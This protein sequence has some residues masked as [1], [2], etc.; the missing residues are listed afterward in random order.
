[1]DIGESLVGAYMRH[2]RNCHTIAFNQFTPG[3]QGEIDVIGI[4]GN[5]SDQK[6][7]IAEVAIHLDGLNYGTYAE[8]VNKIGAKI[9]TAIEYSREIYRNDQPVVEF[10]AP[11]VARGLVERLAIP[12]V[13]FVVNDAF[14][15]RVNELAAIAATSTK[16]YGDASFRFLQLLTHLRGPAPVFQLPARSSQE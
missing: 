6:V 15:E 9:S 11:T 14:T 12:G 7:W 13:E 3:K 8:T 2:K 1:M 10:W 16:Q 5:V 4:S